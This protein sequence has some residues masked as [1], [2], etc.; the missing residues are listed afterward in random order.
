[1]SYSPF[2]QTLHDEKGPVGRLGNGTH[3]SVLRVP[4]WQD[5]WLSPL[6][7]AL[8]LDFAVIWDADHDT[9][10]MEVI[11][12]IY[13]HGLLA[14][15][16]FIGERKGSLS[17]LVSDDFGIASGGEKY[18]DYCEEINE[19]GSSLKDPWKTAVH[20]VSSAAHSIIH[21]PMDHVELYLDTIHL[22]WSLGPKPPV[23]MLG[24][25]DGGDAGEKF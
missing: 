19:I 21:A 7:E 4:I 3:Y 23:H 8:M 15:I 20:A 14:P 17:V 25:F 22:L 10:V 12:A 16:R 11:E 6:S 24:Y 18:K 2:F 1:M 13:L 9:R 5:T